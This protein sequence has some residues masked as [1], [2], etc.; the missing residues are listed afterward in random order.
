MTQNFSDLISR[1]QKF[2]DSFFE[3]AFIIAYCKQFVSLKFLRNRCCCWCR[4]KS[5]PYA[6][7]EIF[8]IAA[9]TEKSF[10]AYASEC[11]EF[12]TETYA[13]YCALRKTAS[14]CIALASRLC[15]APSVTEKIYTGFNAVS[16]KDIKVQNKSA[17]QTLEVFLRGFRALSSILCSKSPAATQNQKEIRLDSRFNP[18]A[19]CKP[20]PSLP[21]NPTQSSFLFIRRELLLP[22]LLFPS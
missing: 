1:A 22:A 2:Y 15:H 4:R 5:Y 6:L 11:K 21:H 10:C 8:N 9:R 20:P 13:C 12:F 17:P 14:N 16:H 7:R 3:S 18:A 19:Q